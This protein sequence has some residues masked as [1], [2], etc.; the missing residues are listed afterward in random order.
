M[1]SLRRDME[2]AHARNLEESVKQVREDRLPKSR[3]PPEKSLACPQVEK[4]CAASEAK[5]KKLA[6]ENEFLR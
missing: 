5:S 6:E 2:A 3:I 1:G 4:K